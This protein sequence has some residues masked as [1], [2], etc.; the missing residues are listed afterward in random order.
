MLRISIVHLLCVEP[1]KVLK[2]QFRTCNV[3]KYMTASNKNTKFVWGTKHRTL[4]LEL[5]FY[6]CII[7]ELKTGKKTGNGVGCIYRTNATDN[8]T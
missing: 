8:V 1:Q 3:L 4:G 2:G 5:L 7:T 6:N